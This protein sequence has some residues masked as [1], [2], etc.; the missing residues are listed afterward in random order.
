MTGAALR[1][2]T[3][4]AVGGRAI[5][6]EGPPGSGKTSLAL[7]LIDRG[8]QLIGDDGVSLQLRSGRL[9][10]SPVPNIAGLIEI[11]NVGIFQLATTQAPISLCLTLTSDAP[12]FIERAD[13][14]MVEGFPLPTLK[15]DGSGAASAIRAEHALQRHG[16]PLPAAT[17]CS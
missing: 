9:W 7:M 2:S 13:T 12:R 15:F 16:L 17:D 11:R 3:C 5:L 8:A 10:A 6:I 4:V 1:Q 14:A